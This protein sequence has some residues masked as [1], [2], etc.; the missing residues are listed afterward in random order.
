MKTY[1]CLA[2]SRKFPRLVTKNETSNRGSGP[3]LNLEIGAPFRKEGLFN[4]PDCFSR[5]G[6][7]RELEL[8]PI[9]S[10]VAAM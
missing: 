4:V 6:V 3:K 2:D 10:A 5:L 1:Q 7:G 8:G 9:H